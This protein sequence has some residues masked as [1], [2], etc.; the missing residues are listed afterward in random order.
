MEFCAQGF[1]L[2]AFVDKIGVRRDTISEW[3]RAHPDFSAA[4][5]RAK[6]A[7]T[8]CWDERSNCISDEGGPPGAPA[9]VIFNL[10][11]FAPDNFLEKQ[12][13]RHSIDPLVSERRQR[14][15]E[16]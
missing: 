11:N 14:H 3:G 2:I 1:S 12:G 5:K 7:A 9:M 13:V 8:L 4:V 10:K 15:L 6:A 16:I